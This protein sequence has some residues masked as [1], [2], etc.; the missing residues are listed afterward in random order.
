MITL[1]LTG[2]ASTYGP[3]SLLS[4]GYTESLIQ[5]NIFRVNFKGKASD[6]IGRVNDFALLRSAEITIQNGY[7]YFIVIEGGT[8]IKTGVVSTPAH[9][10]MATGMI[11]GGHVSS[12]SKPNASIVIQCYKEKPENVSGIIYDATQV[13]S[14]IKS[15]YKINNKDNAPDNETK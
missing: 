15:Q 7:S 8:T 9:I 1:F 3:E 6:S 5:D 10:N 11:E 2:C 12:Y 4:G 13:R 14:N